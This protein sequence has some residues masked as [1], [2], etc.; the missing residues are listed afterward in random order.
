MLAA[1]RED[2]GIRAVP[3]K[4][5]ALAQSVYGDVSLR[6]FGDLDISILERDVLKAHDLIRCLGYEVVSEMETD[7]LAEHI[8]ISP[9]CELQLKRPDGVMV[10][11]HW[12]FARRSAHIGQDPAPFLWRFE[13]IELG[14]TQVRSLSLEAYFMILSMHA[15]KHKWG[16]LKLICDIAEILGRSDVDWSYLVR[17]ANALGLR[18]MLAVGTLLA[19]DPLGAAVPAELARG[20]KIDQTARAVAA[21]I[22]GGL[23]EEP[24]GYWHEP[25]DLRFERNIRER[26]RDR[27]VLGCQE[28]WDNLHPS[29]RD[30]RFV[31]L[32]ESLSSLYYLVRPIRW[33]WEKMGGPIPAQKIT[34]SHESD[35]HLVRRRKDG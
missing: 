1:L 22:R 8:R 35:R 20:L 13:T 33:A 30:R 21:Q 26:L 28:L 34:S 17:D 14:G 23:F 31:A 15:T 24:D 9:D 16:Q 18:R 27:A 6:P 25:A 10:E 32:P 11:L 2:H 12:R 3:Y 19:E 7:D 5:P 29:D 4:G